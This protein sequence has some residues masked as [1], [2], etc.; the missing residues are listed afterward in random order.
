MYYKECNAQ[1]WRGRGPW[2]GTSGLRFCGDCVCVTG[3]TTTGGGRRRACRDVE[4]AA[5]LGAE[6]AVGAE[7]AGAQSLPFYACALRFSL[8]AQ[9]VTRFAMLQRLALLPPS[10]M[11]RLVQKAGLGAC[12]PP[13]S[14]RL[15]DLCN[16]ASLLP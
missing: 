10:R 12:V 11:A 9:H 14:M 5:G 4:F 2:V 16:F 3:M 15:C 13:V 7:P 6:Y 8:Q 1:E